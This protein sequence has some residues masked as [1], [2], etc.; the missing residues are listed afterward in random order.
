MSGVSMGKGAGDMLV[1]SDMETLVAVEMGSEVG[2][3]KGL[4]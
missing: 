1:D 2:V 4:K 3:K